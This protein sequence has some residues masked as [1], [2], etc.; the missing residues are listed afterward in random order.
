MD[1]QPLLGV[2]A[3]VALAAACGFRV[4]VPL[5]VASIAVHSG[6]MQV[7]EG[8]AWVGST[9]ALCCLAAATAFEI[10]GYYLP[11]VDHFLDVI[12]T[13]AAVVA[14]TLVTASFVTDMEP[15]MR[16]STALIAG[17]GAAAAVQGATVVARGISG[18]TTLGLGNP[19]VATAELVGSTAVSILAVVA[20]IFALALI[21]GM[22]WWLFRRF[23]RRK[24]SAATQTSW[25]GSPAS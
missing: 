15:W 4:F 13:P 12:A 9:P 8:F 16:W 23:T 21:A 10:G 5:L 20:P 11:G 7:S 2:I 17:G 22:A 24:S 1:L 14:G 25:S 18:I 19:I 3:G 6:A